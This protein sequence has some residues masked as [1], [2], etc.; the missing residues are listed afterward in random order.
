M[1]N[2]KGIF[3]LGHDDGMRGTEV[4]V[5]SVS[6][7]LPSEPRKATTPYIYFILDYIHKK[8]IKELVI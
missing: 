2:L 6:Y 4:V 1:P 5:K 7:R 8:T 3:F